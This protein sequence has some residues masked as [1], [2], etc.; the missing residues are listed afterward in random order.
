MIPAEKAGGE[1]KDKEGGE[2]PD[3]FVAGLQGGEADDKEGQDQVELF[4]DTKRPGMGKGSMVCEIEAEV[5]G[6]GKE[7][8]ERRQFTSF[9]KP[10]NGEVKRE[11]EKIGG[12]NS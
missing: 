5:L 12:D 9:F 8:P 11:Y 3:G 4:F 6:E 10:G 7:T 1:A 2:Q